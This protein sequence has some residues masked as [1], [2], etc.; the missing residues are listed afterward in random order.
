MIFKQFFLKKNNDSLS[1]NGRRFPPNK[2]HPTPTRSAAPI[3]RNSLQGQENLFASLRD[4]SYMKF[5]EGEKKIYGHS[6]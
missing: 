3:V 2:L 6:S 5:I 1:P 4:A